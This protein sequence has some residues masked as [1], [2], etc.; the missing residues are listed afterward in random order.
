LKKISEQIAL[1]LEIT[2]DT[3]FLNTPKKDRLTS[4]LSSN[5]DFHDSDSGYASHNFH[6]FPAKFPPQLPRKFIEGLTQPGDIILDPMMGSG[7]TLVEAY[8]SN[9]LG[10]GLDIDPLALLITKTKTTPVNIE[11][12][13]LSFQQVIKHARERK[14]EGRDSLLEA[15]HLDDST[16]DFIKY[17]FAPE[18]E[19][20][21]AALIYEIDQLP[22]PKIKA[23][24]KLAFSAIII[25]KSGGV[26]LAL[27]L[28][29]TRPHRAKIVFDQEGNEII[30]NKNINSETKH[31]DI[32]TKTLR[33]P[34]VEFEKKYRNNIKGLLPIYD[35][36]SA[37]L[38]LG[39]N[40]EAMPFRKNE[41]DLIITS[42]PYASNAIDYMR[43]HK[44]SLVWLGYPLNSLSQKRNEYIGGES[45]TGFLYEIMPDLADQTIH[46]ITLKDKKKGLVLHRYFSE[47]T[48]VLRE[49]YRVLKPG[50]SAII[51]VGSSTIKGIDTVTHLCLSQIGQEVGFE[52]PMIGNRNLDRDRRML[53]ASKQI[54]L[55]SQ[56]QQRMHEEYV[57]GFYKPD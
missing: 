19:I 52:I 51:V 5:L 27:D 14:S 21:L 53:P 43:A 18:T 11:H 15:I 40:A 25:T 45:T 24:L 41:V 26:S 35:R 1:P 44:F 28:A 57:I 56:I 2:V 16:K 33:S 12:L 34:F 39:G 46:T 22:D 4:I 13:D 50:G 17:W 20:E 38:I 42:P 48:R 31:L 54:N 10:I 36:S 32:L 47:M 9:R 55:G 8:I 37:P 29:H 49:M 23:F 7:T 6:S 30:R 3:D